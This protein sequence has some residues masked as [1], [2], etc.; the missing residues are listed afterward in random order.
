M[1]IKRKIP[2]AE[3]I[4]QDLDKYYSLQ[5]TLNVGAVWAK[6]IRDFL[7]GDPA[8]QRWQIHTRNRTSCMT[9]FPTLRLGKAYS[10]H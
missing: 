3:V 5:S 9:M 6:R 2:H 8:R 7:E 10:T 1:I 4:V